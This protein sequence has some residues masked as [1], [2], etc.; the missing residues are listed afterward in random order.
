MQKIKRSSTE[1]KEK[2]TIPLSEEENKSYEEQEAC[3]ICKKKFCLDENYENDKND[4][5]END[6]NDEKFKKYRKVQDHC[7]YTRKF[8]GTAH[9]NCNLRYKI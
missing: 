1:N 7:H 5:N 2:G 6:E 8:R 4:E 3:H 9:S